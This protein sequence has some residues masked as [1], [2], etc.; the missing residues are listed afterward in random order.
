MQQEQRRLPEDLRTPHYFDEDG[1]LKPY[2]QKVLDLHSARS[3]APVPS[4]E[5]AYEGKQPDQDVKKDQDT[6]RL[7]IEEVH[8]DLQ[9]AI[10]GEQRGE[11]RAGKGASFKRPPPLPDVLKYDVKE[12]VKEVTVPD[13]LKM[14]KEQVPVGAGVG[15]GH[16]P[17]HMYQRTHMDETDIAKFN[18]REDQRGLRSLD[19]FM[20]SNQDKESDLY[21][22]YIK[23]KETLAS[24]AD[25]PV[26]VDSKYMEELYSEA[27]G[28]LPKAPDL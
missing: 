7:T 11:A 17:L 24:R 21:Q 22:A 16:G 28:N 25:G 20:D 8:P 10:L 3:Q 5:P 15:D 6:N 18:F 13:V 1:N 27:K 9:E 12:A 23:S 26:K 4:S 19:E 14:I 2:P